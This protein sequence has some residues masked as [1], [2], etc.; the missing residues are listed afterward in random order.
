MILTPSTS[1]SPPTLAPKNSFAS[2]GRRSGDGSVELTQ[3]VHGA[4]GADSF[5]K[6]RNLYHV[7]ISYVVA[8][9][10]LYRGSAMMRSKFAKASSKLRGTDPQVKKVKGNNLSTCQRALTWRSGSVCD[11]VA[12]SERLHQRVLAIGTRAVHHFF[13]RRYRLHAR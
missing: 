10:R 12:G 6:M 1:A 2:K 4:V 8:Y 11:L 7:R 3:F 9:Y 5:S 13:E